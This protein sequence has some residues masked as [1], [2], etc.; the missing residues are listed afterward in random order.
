MKQ[1]RDPT[2]NPL[3]E[4]AHELMHGLSGPSGEIERRRREFTGVEGP[5]DRS[6][7]GSL[8]HFIIAEILRVA[9]KPEPPLRNYGP[10]LGGTTVSD[11]QRIL[12][13]LARRWA[14][15]D[16]S[17]LAKSATWGDLLPLVRCG[18]NSLTFQLKGLVAEGLVIR[19]RTAGK[20]R[21]SI[22]EKGIEELRDLCRATVVA[23]GTP[24]EPNL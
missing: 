15:E 22:T 16:Q 13:E 7:D 11:S 12:I 10:P 19:E 8:R 4:L 17:S 20:I 9:S 2:Y 1:S 24:P 6:K 23:F 21:L 5:I 3:V 14:G 18:K